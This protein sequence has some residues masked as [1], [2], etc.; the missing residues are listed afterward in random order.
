V[1]GILGYDVIARLVAVIAGLWL[2]F[3]PA[4]LDYGDPAQSNDRIFG[5][6]AA[7]ASFVALWE[8]ARALRWA[9]LPIGIWLIVSPWV[10]G[11]DTG[12]ATTSTIGV[13]IVLTV[14]TFFGAEVSSR[15]DGGWMTV[16][17]GRGR[18]R[19]DPR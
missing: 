18:W 19:A 17:P 3:A 11:Y 8:I 15:F 1:V 13:G 9:T 7:A 10:L 2:M 12:A 4:V 14:T 16:M 5:P 6:I